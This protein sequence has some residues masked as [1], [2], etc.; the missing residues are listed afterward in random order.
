MAELVLIRHSQASFGASNYDQLSDLGHRQSEAVGD[1][2]RAMQWTPDR[3]I[4]GSLT[5]QKQTLAG[6]GFIENP[7]IHAGFDEYDFHDLLHTRFGGKAPDVVMGDRKTHFRTL[8][9]TI[10]EWQRG[11]IQGT[12]ES[13]TDFACRTSDAMR[14]ATETDA[15]RVLV[16]SSGGVIGQLVA[17]N[18]HAPD[19]MM[20][21]LNLQ[22]KNSSITRFVFSKG[23]VMLDGFNATPHF[24]SN[25]DMLSY[26]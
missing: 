12:K 14:F 6:M 22:I 7:E 26:S 13:W 1:V 23:R 10:L 15:R 5:R 4:T 3:L 20:M 24:D 2:L 25:P 16:I 21:E 11:D 8:R 18:L 9:E 17:R 19:P